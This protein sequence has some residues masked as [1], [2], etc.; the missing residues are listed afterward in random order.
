MYEWYKNIQK[1]VE[2]IDVCIKKKNDEAISFS[3]LA[4][5]LGYSEHYISRKFSKISGMTFRDYLRYRKLAFSLKEI[6][7]S[8]KSI[9]DIALDYG[10]FQY[11]LQSW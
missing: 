7:D 10:Y 5:R 9:L 3:Y 4:N 1:L 8:D 6:R 2:E 11:L